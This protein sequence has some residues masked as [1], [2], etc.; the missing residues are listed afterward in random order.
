MERERE[1][2]RGREGERERGREGE[3][4]RKRTRESERGR[5][6]EREGERNRDNSKTSINVRRYRCQVMQVTSLQ[7]TVAQYI[8]VYM[9]QARWRA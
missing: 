3:R 8:T 1:R 6:R 9:T 2:E 5:K 7:W 4:E